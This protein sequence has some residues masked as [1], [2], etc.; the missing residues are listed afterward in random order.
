[1]IVERA[2]GR[3]AYGGIVED[4]NAIIGIASDP[5]GIVDSITLDTVYGP[6]I[7]I[8]EPLKTDA[9]GN[10]QGDPVTRV[11]K[12]KVTINLK[13]GPPIVYAPA[14]E[15]GETKWPYVKWGMIGAGALIGFL[16]LRG[17]TR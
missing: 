17:M 5:A 4:V 6:Q 15:P 1:M 3:R 16:I 8:S 2:T 12:P 9:S 10:V 7:L 13:A 14:G 11:L